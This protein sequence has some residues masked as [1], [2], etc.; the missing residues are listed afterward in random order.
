GKN[1]QDDRKCVR[2]SS[3]PSFH[4]LPIA[5]PSNVR[6]AA[7]FVQ[8]EGTCRKLGLLRAW[9]YAYRLRSHTAGGARQACHTHNGGGGQG[10][11]PDRHRSPAS[12]AGT[13]PP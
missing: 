4:H 6:L 3:P 5:S 2:P 12:R 1:R 13:P 8:G 9:F 11:P 7:G 10:T